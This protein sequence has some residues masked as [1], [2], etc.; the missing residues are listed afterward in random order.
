MLSRL[1]KRL[2]GIDLLE[3][4]LEVTMEELAQD[5]VKVARRVRQLERDIADL[6]IYL[7]VKREES[8][9]EDTQNPLNMPKLTSS[10]WV[11]NQRDIFEIAKDIFE[12]S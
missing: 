10:K 3:Y 2:F 4:K 7:D 1:V 8:W 12:K 11:K 9:Q 5:D 6:L